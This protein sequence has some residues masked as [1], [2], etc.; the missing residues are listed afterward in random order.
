[1]VSSRNQNRSYRL[2]RNNFDGVNA[3]VMPQGD[4]LQQ[5][6]A[7]CIRFDSSNLFDQQVALANLFRNVQ[8]AKH[9]SAVA[10]HIKYLA[11][12]RFISRRKKIGNVTFIYPTGGA[13][14]E[15]Q[16]YSVLARRN[17]DCIG[18]M[19]PTL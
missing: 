15:M 16:T 18:E 12:P 7:L 6:F 9:G 5:N 17:R 11:I 3:C 14:D 8:V 19:S 4:K 1:M 2:F 10:E 13:P